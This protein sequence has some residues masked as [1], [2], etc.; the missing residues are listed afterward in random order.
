MSHA[1]DL[2]DEQE[3]LLEPVFNAPGKRRTQAR[4]GPAARG[5]AHH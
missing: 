3:A 2:T 5:R 1:N 4:A